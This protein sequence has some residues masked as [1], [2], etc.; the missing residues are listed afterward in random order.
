[1]RD[2]GSDIPVAA[3]E[4]GIGVVTAEDPVR[5][6]GKVDVPLVFLPVFDDF[7]PGDDSFSRLDAAVDNPLFFRAG[8]LRIDI[9]AV[10]AGRYQDF[11]AGAGD[12]GGFGDIPEGIFL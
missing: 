10:D 5:N 7:G 2:V 4:S 8:L 1:M 6:P 9:F 12:R 3:D 11:I